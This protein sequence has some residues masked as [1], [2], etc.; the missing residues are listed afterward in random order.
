MRFPKPE[1]LAPKVAAIRALGCNPRPKT[2]SLGKGV[3]SFH[4]GIASIAV[5]LDGFGKDGGKY[6]SLLL[7]SI[8]L[9][10]VAGFACAKL[11]FL[12]EFLW[13]SLMPFE[14]RCRLLRV[15]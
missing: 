6:G 3:K 1:N 13:F 10:I 9:G 7:Q 8:E 14:R 11:P 5:V 12:F 4:P 15:C 2:G